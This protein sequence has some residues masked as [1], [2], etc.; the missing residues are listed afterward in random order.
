MTSSAPK[1]VSVLW[2][3]SDE[4]L[5]AR[6]ESV[7]AEAVKSAVSVLEKNAAFSRR[8]R[9][10][11]QIEAANLRVAT[12]QHGEARPTVHS[13]G[14][15]FADPQLHT[16]AVILNLARR[17]DGTI[18]TLDGRRLFAWKMATGAAYHLALA[19]GLQ[20]LG[21]H[22]CDIGRNGMFKIAGV[23]GQLTDYFSARRAEVVAELDQA[24][25]A[26]AAAP[27]FAG[28]ITKA[29]RKVKATDTDV[30]RDRF[31]LWHDAAREQG[32]E[33]DRLV[34]DAIEARDPKAKS[35]KEIRWGQ[36]ILDQVRRVPDEL[37]QSES[38]FERRH[39]MAAVASTM[40]GSGLS[41]ERAEQAMEN[42]VAKGGV[43][44][45]G[46]NAVG[47]MCY[48][49]PEIMRIAREIL[50]LSQTL[51][52]RSMQEPDREFVQQ[53][54]STSTLTSEQSAAVAAATTV[55]ALANIE[56]VAGSGKTTSLRPVVEAH[57][58]AGYRVLGCATAWRTAH[59]LRDDLG[60]EAKATDAWL[61][62][63][64]VGHPFLDNKTLLIVDEAGQLSSRQMHTL[65]SH[66]EQSGANSCSLNT[67][68][69]CSRLV[70]AA[71]FRSSREHPS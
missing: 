30:A 2:A 41:V 60:I 17:A 70:L 27:A 64:A 37:T 26:S 29:S 43:V 53:L 34:D 8:G 39:L 3:L 33:A 10:G 58:A 20:E 46:A 15:T 54:I 28:A 62:G 38:V 36:A 61:V 9:N 1:S 44:E 24:G 51:V 14:R 42:L 67:A 66:V 48:S 16:H 6:I 21:F 4:D 5:R 25:L 59:Q 63:H 11:L 65:L 40:V 19:S 7:Q 57:R 69:S 50:T 31:A 68:D 22:V 12:F 23:D 45:L 71:R 32:Y 55:N 52:A 49:T 35:M 56:G 13:D 47:E 18:G